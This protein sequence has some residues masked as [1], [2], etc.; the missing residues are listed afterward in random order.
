MKRGN[1]N[2]VLKRVGLVGDRV[3]KLRESLSGL[4]RLT[5]FLA[6]AIEETKPSKDIKFRLK[7]LQR[8]V[9]SITDQDGFVTARIS[10][11]LD[12]TL[13]LISIE[14]NAIIKIFSVAATAFLPPTLIASIY[15]MNFH[16]M[17]ELDWHFGYP[18]AIILMIASAILPLWYFRRR[19]WL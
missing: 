10:F 17:P 2:D 13:G 7:T 9:K 6:Q 3:S 5:L 4:S 15:G 19:G 16:F 8:D 14:Q 12:A 11:L 1:L 18:M